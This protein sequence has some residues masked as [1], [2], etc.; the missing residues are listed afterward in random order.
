MPIVEHNAEFFPIT[1]L[2][3]CDIL[4]HFKERNDKETFK[5]V[6]DIVKDMDDGDMDWLA[7]K[8]GDAY[9]GNGYWIDLEIIFE[10]RF[11]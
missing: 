4:G 3:K 1:H 5:K 6:K 7:N 10:N 8:M 2:S 11:M 9:T